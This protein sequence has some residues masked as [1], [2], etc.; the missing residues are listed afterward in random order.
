M[1]GGNEYRGRDYIFAAK[2]FFALGAYPSQGAPLGRVFIFTATGS[3]H[4]GANTRTAAG[5]PLDKVHTEGH[6]GI[7][8]FALGA[9]TSPLGI[10]GHWLG[11][12]HIQFLYR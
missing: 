4:W 9:Y 12:S 1:V 6:M 10:G 7:G 11:C 8:L 3:L 5:A 2:G